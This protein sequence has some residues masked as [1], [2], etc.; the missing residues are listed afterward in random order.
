MLSQVGYLYCRFFS[1]VYVGVW[2]IQ[3]IQWWV[4]LRQWYNF[5]WYFFLESLKPYSILTEKMCFGERMTKSKGSQNKAS[6][7]N[8]L[9]VSLW[10]A[11]YLP[12]KV[13]SGPLLAEIITQYSINC[14]VI[15]ICSSSMSVHMWDNK[16][17]N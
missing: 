12:F 6:D 11:V 10:K 15:G 1:R 13:C 3:C 5:L 9:L 17:I 16:F 14:Q 4:C 7:M 8:Y 2:S